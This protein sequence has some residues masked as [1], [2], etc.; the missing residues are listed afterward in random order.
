MQSIVLR[1]IP[2]LT[3][4][5]TRVIQLQVLG[6]RNIMVR[7][8]L[9][10][11]MLCLCS[12]RWV[13]NS[14][15]HVSQPLLTMTTDVNKVFEAVSPIRTVQKTYTLMMLRFSHFV[16]KVGFVWSNYEDSRSAGRCLGEV[17][18]RLVSYL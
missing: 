16:P 11:F 1:W 7:L 10:E 18:W 5:M 2:S 13:G 12:L 15:L 17:C 14:Q 3:K 4:D 8:C 6:R 9:L